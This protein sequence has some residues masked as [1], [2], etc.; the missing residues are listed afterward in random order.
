MPEKKNEHMTIADHV[1]I[2]KGFWRQGELRE[3]C[4]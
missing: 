4:Q 2:E 1:E 3:D